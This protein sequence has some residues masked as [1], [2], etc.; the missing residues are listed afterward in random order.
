M[1]VGECVR[2]CASVCMHARERERGRD[3]PCMMIT[4]KR[5]SSGLTFRIELEW[6]IFFSSKVKFRSSSDFR[7]AKTFIFLPGS[8][9]MVACS[10]R[11]RRI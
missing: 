9:K 6:K 7:P 3:D 2:V 11:D 1:C 8:P 5:S 4:V 10:H